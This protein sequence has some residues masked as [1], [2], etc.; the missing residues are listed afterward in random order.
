MFL[1]NMKAVENHFHTQHCDDKWSD[2]SPR[3]RYRHRKAC[4][5][6]AESGPYP[7][8]IRIQHTD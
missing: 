4:K 2:Y 5:A 8:D 1:I 7:N 6:S 3:N